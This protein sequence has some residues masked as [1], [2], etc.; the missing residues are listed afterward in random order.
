MTSIL[1]NKSFE[2]SLSIIS[3]VKLL[4]DQHEFIFANQLLRS[5]TSIGANKY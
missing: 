1:E 3:L 4:R 2:F 5:A